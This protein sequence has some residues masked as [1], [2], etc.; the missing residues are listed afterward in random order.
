MTGKSEFLQGDE[1]ISVSSNEKILLNH[2]TFTVQEFKTEL[3]SRINGGN[4][5][6][7]RKWCFDGVHCKLLSPKQRWRKGTIKISLEFIP[8]E[9]KITEPESPLD[10]IRREINQG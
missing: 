9:P 10:D 6:K 2:K 4:E 8:D 7:T 3:T 5:K 1:V